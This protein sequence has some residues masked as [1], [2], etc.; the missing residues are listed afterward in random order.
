[1]FILVV[2]ARKIYSYIKSVP[3][4]GFANVEGILGALAGILMVAEIRVR[5]NVEINNTM[6]IFVIVVLITCWYIKPVVQLIWGNE[7]DI[8]DRAL[9]IAVF[10]ST[11]VKIHQALQQSIMS[12]VRMIRSAFSTLNQELNENLPFDTVGAFPVMVWAFSL[13]RAYTDVGFKLLATA[14]VL[15]V[16]Q[17]L[18]LH[19]SKKPHQCLECGKNFR[20]HTHFVRHQRVHNGEK[21]N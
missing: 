20:K 3:T 12:G 4:E 10:I 11:I 7:D 2:A 21:A 15:M 9:I 17:V 6:S 19:I 8:L 16:T 1:M 13:Y 14:S 18:L 5:P